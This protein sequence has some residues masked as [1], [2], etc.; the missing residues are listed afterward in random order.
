MLIIVII[1]DGSM[2]GKEPDIYEYAV[3]LNQIRMQGF[4][5]LTEWRY[6]SIKD[7]SHSKDT[8][9]GIDNKYSSLK[10]LEFRN[11]YDDGHNS[12]HDTSELFAA[13]SVS[14][15]NCCFVFVKYY[16]TNP[17][18]IAKNNRYFKTERK[19]LQSQQTQYLKRKVFNNFS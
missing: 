1:S 17:S 10:W 6:N 4:N 13:P 8:G 19:Y 15:L 5:V 12:D 2:S 16:F 9:Q 14:F 11:L 7:I 18:E 3:Q